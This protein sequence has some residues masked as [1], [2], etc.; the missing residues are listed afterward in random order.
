MTDSLKQRIKTVQEIS[1]LYYE[2]GRHDRS[3]KWVWRYKVYPIIP[4][5]YRVFLNYMKIQL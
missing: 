5:C 4:I 1:R 3:Y 2:P